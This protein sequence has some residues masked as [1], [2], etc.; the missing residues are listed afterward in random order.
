M[1]VLGKVFRLSR[2]DRWLLLR[3]F[4]AVAS[5]WVTVRL[6][7][8]SVV[9][10]K[11]SE[12]IPLLSPR[13]PQTTAR[14][15]WAI[16]VAARYIPGSKCLVQAFAGRNLLASYGFPGTIHIGVAKDS[17]NWLSAHAWV[18]VE[19]RTVIGGDTAAYA[20]LIGASQE[21]RP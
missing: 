9:L 19:G 7:P 8:P 6:F 2:G 11:V 18:E 3:A 13:Q 1:G 16:A 12:D 10:R 14:I 4:A 17:R 20:P 21:Y 5:A 15:G